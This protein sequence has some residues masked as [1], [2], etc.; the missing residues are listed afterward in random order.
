LT[1]R[2]TINNVGP[3]FDLRF[4]FLHSEG[5][6]GGGP[7][8]SS[9]SS[10][11]CSAA[12]SVS[13]LEP[14]ISAIICHPIRHYDSRREGEKTTHFL[15]VHF[16][17]ATTTTTE[18]T[19]TTHTAHTTHAAHATH[20]THTAHA[21]HAAHTHTT[22]TTHID[23]II[24]G[25]IAVLLIL[26]NPLVKVGLDVRI[27]CLILRE[28]GPVFTFEILFTKIED[29]GARCKTVSRFLAEKDTEY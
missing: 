7:S 2:I 1:N 14:F 12:A 26:I 5:S 21:A 25:L 6:R 15:K 11:D 19:H 16:S 18:S 3:S 20:A 22:H 28:A 9:E 13:S 4:F 10:S 8:S 29:E 24:D 23:A 17:A 27:L